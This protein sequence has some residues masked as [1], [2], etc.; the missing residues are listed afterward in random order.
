[1]TLLTP[2]RLWECPN[3]QQTDVTHEARPHTRFHNCAGLMGLS[4]PMIP[5]GTSAKVT[6]HEREDYIGTEDVAMV[7]GRPIMSIITERPDGSNDVA[8]FA[9]TAHMTGTAT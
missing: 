6:L 9:P 4:A 1:M 8:V 3:C 5:A 2:T 7:N